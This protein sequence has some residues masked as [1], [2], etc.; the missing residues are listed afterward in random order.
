M[1]RRLALFH[2]GVVLALTL[3]CSAAYCLFNGPCSLLSADRQAY[4]WFSHDD[5]AAAARRFADPNWRATALFRQGDFE[6]AAA[7]WAGADTPEGTFNHGNAL[8][9]QGL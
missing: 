5:Y 9:L 1:K 8:L 6:Q 3:L 2:P 7:I 4:R